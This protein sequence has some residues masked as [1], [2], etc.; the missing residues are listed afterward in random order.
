MDT[1]SFGTDLANNSSFGS[2]H[3]QPKTSISHFD[4]SNHKTKNGSISVDVSFKLLPHFATENTEKFKGM[5]LTSVHS[6]P[7]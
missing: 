7:Y 5:T 2:L 1:V 3:S 6:N 4:H